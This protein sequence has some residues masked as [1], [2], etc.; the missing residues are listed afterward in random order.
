MPEA[1]GRGNTRAC[2]FPG[3]QWEVLR[4]SAL[5][6]CDLLCVLGGRWY[7]DTRPS[8]VVDSPFFWSLRF[9]WWFASAPVVHAR[10][11]LPLPPEGLHMSRDRSSYGSPTPT[12]VHYSL[13]L[14]GCLPLPGPDFVSQVSV[15]SPH[16]MCPA[17][18][19]ITC[20]ALSLLCPPQ[21]S[22]CTLI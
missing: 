14:S 7:L 21:T 16:W 20:A 10:G 19:P 15:P 17:V 5:L 1:L 12:V 13:A 4:R 2:T 11:A 22:C 8:V 9:L 18:V 6:G 3:R